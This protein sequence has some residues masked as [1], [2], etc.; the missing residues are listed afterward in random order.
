[1]FSQLSNEMVD[2]FE[3]HE[4]LFDLE[5][6]EENDGMGMEQILSGLLNQVRYEGLV[7]MFVSGIS[8]FAVGKLPMKIPRC[9]FGDDGI[10][11]GKSLQFP[12]QGSGICNF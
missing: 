4:G 11:F 8:Y 3:L 12:C 5:K 7:S 10:A 1:M 9:N 2:S 6:Y